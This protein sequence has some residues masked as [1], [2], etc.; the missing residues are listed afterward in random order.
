MHPELVDRIDRV[1]I[2]VADEDDARRTGLRGALER[3]GFAVCA[4]EADADEAVSATLRERPDV[5]VLA[6]DLPGGALIATGE[7]ADECPTTRIVLLA[8]EPEEEDCLTS[9]QA[10]ASAYMAGNAPPR[11]LAAALRDVVAGIPSIPR[12][13]QPR[14]LQELRLYGE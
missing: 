7:I 12:R 3:Q 10:G 5:C 11:R 8:A 13:F 4:E 1:R 14:L 2:V 9:L 6:A